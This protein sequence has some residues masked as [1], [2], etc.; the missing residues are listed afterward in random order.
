M[1]PG[2]LINQNSHLI[3]SRKSS[4][5][6]NLVIVRSQAA[7]EASSLSSLQGTVSLHRTHT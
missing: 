6:N 3:A 2:Y 5:I 1:V 7:L 4:L